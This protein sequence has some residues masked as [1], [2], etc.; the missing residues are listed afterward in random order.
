MAMRNPQLWSL[1]S[2]I[3][4][5]ITISKQ[6]IRSLH[7]KT[8]PSVPSPTPFVPDVQTFLTLIGRDMSKQASKIPSWESLFTSTS[9]QLRDMGIEPARQRRYLIRKREK[10][11]N[12]VYGPG[13]DLEQVVDGVAQLRVVEVPRE[14]GSVEKVTANAVAG[15]AAEGISSATLTPGMKKAIVNLAPEATEYKHS[16]SAVL[17]KFA[18]MKIHRGS[19]I[20]G[21]YLQPIKGSHGSAATITVQPGMWEDKR[22]HK[23]DGGERRRTEVRAKKRLEEIRKA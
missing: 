5:S 22:G 8:A 1:P 9:T 7:R 18:H 16:P 19:K 14:A 3:S 15:A 10:F 13:G 20:M 12:G 23:V 6:C 2:R 4:Q 11:R 21:P 17:K